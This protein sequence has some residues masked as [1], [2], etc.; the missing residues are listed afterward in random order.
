MRAGSRQKAES[1]RQKAE[2]RRQLAHFPCQIECFFVTLTDALCPCL[3][4]RMPFPD[5]DKGWPPSAFLSD[6]GSKCLQKPSRKGAKTAKCAKPGGESV[7]MNLCGSA[8]PRETVFFKRPQGL[9]LERCVKGTT[10]NLSSGPARRNSTRCRSGSV[11]SP[12]PG[13]GDQRRRA[14]LMSMRTFRSTAPPKA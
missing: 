10:P 11:S 8:P 13:K 1:R 2:C 4:A 14:F 7:G 3:S 12:R 5:N 9:T 6:S